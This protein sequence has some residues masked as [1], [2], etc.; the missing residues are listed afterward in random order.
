[1]LVGLM[2]FYVGATL[3][4]NG[5][6]LIG[7]ARVAAVAAGA[8]GPDGTE[9]AAADVERHPTFIKPAELAIINYFTAGVGV[10]AATV[11]VVFGTMTGDVGYIASAAFI[12]LFGFTYLF[13][14]LNQN[15]GAGNHAFG[16]FCLF[17]AVTAVPIA[18][19]V[20]SNANGNL[21]TIW[22][23]IDWIV[24]AVLWLC[25]FLLLALERPI[26]KQVGWFAIIVAIGTAWALG[27]GI[28]QGSV[29]L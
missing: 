4:I 3:G 16:W 10:V 12:M 18:I 2:L 5:I 26:A 27:Y 22:L 14:A 17:V 23:G 24:W 19:N 1:M 7:Q 6:W 15:T 9:P 20:L 11:L 25:F 21:G 8:S 29:T 13:V 28:L